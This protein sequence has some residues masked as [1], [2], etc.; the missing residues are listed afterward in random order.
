MKTAGQLDIGDVRRQLHVDR[1]QDRLADDQEADA[2]DDVVE[3]RD[4]EEVR[5]PGESGRS[6]GR[7]HALHLMAFCR[8]R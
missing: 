5:Q 3:G 7:A 6:N 8:R 4:E 1:R 2:Q